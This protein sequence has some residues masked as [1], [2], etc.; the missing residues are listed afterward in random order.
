ME[1]AD[2]SLDLSAGNASGRGFKLVGGLVKLCNCVVPVR[3]IYR[4]MGLKYGR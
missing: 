1:V 3:V 2:Y 4:G